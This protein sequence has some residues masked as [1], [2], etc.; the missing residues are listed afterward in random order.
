MPQDYKNYLN[1]LNNQQ[2][3]LLT[4]VVALEGFLKS[5]NFNYRIIHRFTVVNNFF[6]LITKYS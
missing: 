4:K 1:L 3:N 2:L 6:H 5:N